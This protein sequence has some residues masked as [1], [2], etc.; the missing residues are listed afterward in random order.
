MNL[1]CIAYLD[2]KNP[3]HNAL[4][5]AETVG[6]YDLAIVNLLEPTRDCGPWLDVARRINPDLKVIAYVQVA[7][8]DFTPSV[9]GMTTRQAHSLAW[10][11]GET[12]NGRLYSGYQSHAWQ[13]AFHAACDATLRAY[14]VDGL[15]FDNC[16]VWSRHVRR[17]DDGPAMSEALQCVITEQRQR[18]PVQFSRLRQRRLR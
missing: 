17:P 2:P 5:Q 6:R 1:F 12:Y 16:A 8:Q 18:H 13:D 14:P 7:T 15:F 11:P 9:S 4:G 10:L 3:E